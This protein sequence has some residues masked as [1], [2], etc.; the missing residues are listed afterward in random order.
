MPTHRIPHELISMH[1][2]ARAAS[3]A[4]TTLAWI[5]IFNY[6]TQYHVRRL[7]QVQGRDLLPKLEAMGLVT[8]FPLPRGLQK[9]YL[10]TRK[11]GATAAQLLGRDN[12]Y[13]MRPDRLVPA[14]VDHELAVQD[15]V[16]DHLMPQ[17]EEHPREDLLET[18]TCLRGSRELW[19][20]HGQV[21][22]DAMFRWVDDDGARAAHAFECER[23]G[24]SDTRLRTRMHAIVEMFIRYQGRLSVDYLMVTPPSVISRYIATWRHVC[25]SMD[26]ALLLNPS[27][28]FGRNEEVLR[29]A[30]IAC[31]EFRSYAPPSTLFRKLSK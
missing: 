23:H 6:S 31:S 10:L 5:Y 17:L 24:K 25:E 1:P 18:L 19:A 30:L 22:A 26:L 8:S 29:R 2:R 15:C 14:M 12:S 9:A 3:K 7:L 13:R 20:V 21:A 28:E 16:L 11:G 27:S 4:E